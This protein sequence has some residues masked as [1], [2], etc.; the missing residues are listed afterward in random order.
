MGHSLPHR[1]H[2]QLVAGYA[3]LIAPPW[4]EGVSWTE[5]TFSINLTR[6]AVKGSPRYEPAG[7]LQR[8]EEASLYNHYQR[9]SYWADQVILQNPVSRNVAS[10]T[11][12]S[13]DTRI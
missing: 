12:D 1:G 10:A 5:R 13:I 2:E 8:D 4:I 11:R 6:E 7:N 3:V 9:G